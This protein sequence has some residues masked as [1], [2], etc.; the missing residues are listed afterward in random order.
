MDDMYHNCRWCKHNVKGKCTKM[1]EVMESYVGDALYKFSEEGYLAETIRESMNLSQMP[2]HN[3]LGFLSEL[4]ISDKKKAQIE[5]AV[6]DDLEQNTNT[7]VND[8]DSAVARQALDRMDA[9]NPMLEYDL[10]DPE[11]FYCKYWE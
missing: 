7:I 2:L 6:R 9:N 4:K 8:L 1:G 10:I 3:L 11:S 5:Q